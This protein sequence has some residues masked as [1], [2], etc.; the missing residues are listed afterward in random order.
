MDSSGRPITINSTEC[1]KPTSAID[2]IRSQ[3]NIFL[4]KSPEDSSHGL[5]TIDSTECK[6]PAPAIDASRQEDI[7]LG[8]SP[9]ESSR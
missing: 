7:F 8:K 9:K 6:K 2:I 5:I 3:E 4:G 1:K